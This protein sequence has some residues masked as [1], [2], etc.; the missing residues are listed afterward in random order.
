M[1]PRRDYRSDKSA[2]L[3]GRGIARSRW[4]AFQD[5]VPDDVWADIYEA[6]CEQ[7]GVHPPVGWEPG[8]PHPLDFDDPPA[9]ALE[10]IRRRA[11]ERSELLGFYLAWHLAGGF[12][13]LQEAGWHRATLHRK[14]RRFRDHFGQHPD[15]LFFPWLRL[16]PEKAWKEELVRMTKP[17]QEPDW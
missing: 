14:I 2:S 1:A 11:L 5:E 3:E 12:A 15:E 8:D 4:K 13:N 9:E 17:A 16:D 7:W 6:Q 10:Q